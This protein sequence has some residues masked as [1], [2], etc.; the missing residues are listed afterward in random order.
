MSSQELDACRELVGFEAVAGPVAICFS[1]KTKSIVI[2]LH[3]HNLRD[4]GLRLGESPKPSSTRSS[5]SE[6]HSGLGGPLGG[7]TCQHCCFLG[8]YS[9]G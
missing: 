6:G 5:R 9:Q 4:K 1:R 3:A 2:T 8:E 7:R